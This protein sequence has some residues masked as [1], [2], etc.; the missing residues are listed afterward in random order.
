MNNIFDGLI[1]RAD[2]AEER[3]SELEDMSIETSKTGK[4]R[5]K[6]LKKTKQTLQELQ[7]NN[8]K[9][10][11]GVTGIPEGK[12]REKRTEAIFQTLMNENFPQINVRHKTTD[13]GSSENSKQNK[14]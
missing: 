3:I 1:S 7:D 8:Q 4:R 14:C 13:P 10:N 6:R 11:I 9:Y 12:E 5:E 2:T